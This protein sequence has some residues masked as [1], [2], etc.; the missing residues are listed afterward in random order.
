MFQCQILFRNRIRFT[1]KTILEENKMKY[2]KKVKVK[3]KIVLCAK[4]NASQCWKVYIFSFEQAK[5]SGNT[6][7]LVCCHEH[8][9]ISIFLIISIM[10]CTLSTESPSWELILVLW[11][12]QLF[13]FYVWPWPRSSGELFIYSARMYK[14]II[15]CS[16]L[17][18]TVL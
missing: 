17:F 14:F 9:F 4:I 8:T 7:M 10:R 15:I 16:L 6:K 1:D 5:R 12:R 11:G 3:Q 2:K 18:I 13:Y